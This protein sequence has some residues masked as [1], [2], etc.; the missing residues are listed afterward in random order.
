MAS[1]DTTS[2]TTYTLN[3]AED[4]ARYL[5]NLTQNYISGE[6][7]YSEHER[8]EKCRHSIFDALYKKMGETF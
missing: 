7:D 1:V 2:I 4:E 8:D 5:K 3:L 6:A